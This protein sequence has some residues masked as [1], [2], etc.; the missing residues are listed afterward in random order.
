MANDIATF[1]DFIAVKAP[2]E[3]ETHPIDRYFLNP[4]LEK[5]LTFNRNNF[6]LYNLENRSTLYSE[7]LMLCL[8]ELWEDITVI[9]LLQIIDQFTKTTSFYGLILFT[10]K[11]V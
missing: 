5:I 7:Y 2:K 8:P 3:A 4:Y 9:D 6:L 10:Y 1:S 11:F